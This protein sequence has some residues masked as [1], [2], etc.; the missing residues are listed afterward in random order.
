M[1]S[2]QER[3]RERER[4]RENDQLIRHIASSLTGIYIRLRLKKHIGIAI[5]Y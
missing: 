2:L 4:E 1:I 5:G 3:E